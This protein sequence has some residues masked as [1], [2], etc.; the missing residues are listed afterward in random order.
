[1]KQ[2]FFYY[3]GH[4]SRYLRPGMRRVRLDNLV[5]TE[6]PPLSP[7]DIKNG[8]ALSF[9]P[10]EAGNAVQQFRLTPKVSGKMG[11][12]AAGTD[13]APG[14]DGFGVG[15]ECVEHCISGECWFPKVQLWT[16]KQAEDPDPLHGGRGN[17]GWTINTVPGGSQLVNVDDKGVKTCLTAVTAL[18]WAVGLDAGLTV[19]AAQA[20]PCAAAGSLNQTFLLAGDGEGESISDGA[21]TITSALNGKC[22]QPQLERLPHFDAVAFEHPEDGEIALVVMNTNDDAMPIT[23][24]DAVSGRGVVHSVPG[25]GIHTYRWTPETVVA[26]AATVAA[27]ATA[28]AV[29][30][31]TAT[32]AT[33][34][35]SSADVGANAPVP[36]LP[37]ALI[38]ELPSG[39]R[40]APGLTPAIDATPAGHGYSSWGV[41]AFGLVG[42]LALMAT[43]NRLPPQSGYV[44]AAAEEAAQPPGAGAGA[45]YQAFADPSE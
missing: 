31:T 6:V 41:A 1:M 25:H 30:L 13:T 22:L 3:M 43:T 33:M 36:V 38:A 37:Q 7:A 4:F 42:V 45:D 20:H 35:D 44:S 12:V 19:T 15:G 23:I 34:A 11:L 2:A 8:V 32:V 10:C 26:A 18:G 29:A 5:E 28:A 24:K 14:S 21:L 40:I 16:C 39:S 27:T 9:L 17:Q